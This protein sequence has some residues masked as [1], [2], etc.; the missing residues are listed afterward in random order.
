MTSAPEA[1]ALA[2]ADVA[3]VYPVN[4]VPIE[5]QYPYAAYSA[6][7]GRG[8]SYTLDS[9]EGV[10]WGRVVVQV[11]SKTDAALDAKYEQ[12]RAALDGTSLAITGYETTPC[13]AELDPT[14]VD[15]DPDDAGVIGVTAT[16]TFTATK[17]A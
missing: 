12:I 11:F 13:R 8:D 16:F 14:P 4:Q 15:R 5:P 6:S 17:E 10:R 2:T 3:R 9:R 7:L 1:V